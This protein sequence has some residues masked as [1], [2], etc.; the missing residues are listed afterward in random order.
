[1]AKDL[2][3]YQKGVIKRYYENKD[4]IALQKLSE[5]VSDLWLEKDASKRRRLWASAEAAMVGAGVKPEAAADVVKKQDL[6]KLATITGE[7][8]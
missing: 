4:T 3:P 7:L 1:M 6:N 2:T 5:I 8:F